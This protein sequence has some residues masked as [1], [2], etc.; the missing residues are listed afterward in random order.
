MDNPVKMPDALQPLLGAKLHRPLLPEDCVHRHALL[1]RLVEG[2]KR[3]LTLICAP[4]GY[5]KSCLAIDWLENSEHPSCWLSMDQSDGD[6]RTFIRYTINALQQQIPDICNDLLNRISTSSLP[7]VSSLSRAFSNELENI[8]D[9]FILALDDY[10]LVQGPDIHEFVNHLLELPSRGLHLAIITRHSP[11]LSLS[12]L[13]ASHQI[14]EIR[15][16]DLRFNERDSAYFLDKSSGRKLDAAQAAQIHHS[17]EGWAV[18]LRLAA[19]ALHHQIDLTDQLNHLDG[20]FYEI[21]QYLLNEVLSAL[22]TQDRDWLRK[23]AILDKFTAEL[24]EY[25]CIA[26]KGQSR[27][28]MDGEAFIKKLHDGGLF[29]IALDHRREWHRYHHQFQHLLRE[30]LES[31]Y[32]LA[33]IQALHVKA[34]GWLEQ[35]GQIEHALRH[36]LLGGD[37][38]LARDAIL[39]NR[40]Q[41]FSSEEAYRVQHW[42]GIV[43]DIAA[44]DPE[45]LLVRAWIAQKNTRYAELIEILEQLETILESAR[46]YPE[47]EHARMRGESETL[48]SMLAYWHTNAEAAVAHADTALE[49]LPDQDAARGFAILLK[50][51]ALQMLGDTK[52]ATTFAH[53]LLAQKEYRQGT[54]HGRLLQGLCYN[55]SFDGDTPALLRTCV[56]LEKHGRQNQLPESLEYASYF[57]AITNYQLNNLPEALSLLEPIVANRNLANY[58]VYTSSVCTMCYTH[59]AMGDHTKAIELGESLAES[60]LISGATGSIDMA[61]A[62]LADLALRRNRLTEAISWAD[63]FDCLAPKATTRVIMPEI[64][65]VKVRIAENTTGSQQ[66]V[67]VLL[68]SLQKFLERIHNVRFLTELLALRALELLKQEKR[69]EALSTIENAVRQ[70]QPGGYIR[71][72]VD[73]GPELVPLLS[74]LQLDEQGLE[75]IG[76]ILAAYPASSAGQSQDKATVT[77]LRNAGITDTAAGILSIREQEILM[78]L[79]QRLNNKEISEKLF[80]SPATVKRHAHNIYEKLGVHSRREAVAKATGLGFIPAN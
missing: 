63:T 31:H 39:N 34:A 5:G 49:L 74:Q 46:N 58:H 77:P 67:A 25:L 57:R 36:Y 51:G 27:H 69:T 20:D 76:R 70:A 45:L 32:E 72:F 13:R 41:A 44:Y 4:A 68:E 18:G 19:L 7:L 12:R 62:C 14:N 42:L 28:A 61:Q 65:Y 30:Q 73:L 59:M 15:M 79:A 54:I 66:E 8:E 29:C 9:R 64:A 52:Q 71:L 47:A 26:V 24:C 38:E 78:L 80:I 1:G 11:P 37:K 22:S 60:A 6:L 2:D 10:H 43:G 23:T 35:H 50:I 75:Y 48:R 55:Y 16:G 33:E 17:T 56:A 21:Q 3:S 40:Q 53:A